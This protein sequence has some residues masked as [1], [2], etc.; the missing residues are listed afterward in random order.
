MPDGSQYVGEFKFGLQD[1]EGML[2]TSDGTEIF[3]KW[4]EGSYEELEYTVSANEN[5]NSSPTTP[6]DVDK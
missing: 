1:G 2:T 5:Q 6:D 4:V 3:G